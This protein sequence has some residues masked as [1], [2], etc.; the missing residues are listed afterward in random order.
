MN[1][2][3]KMMLT[4]NLSNIPD[5]IVLDPGQIS[6]KGSFKLDNSSPKAFIITTPTLKKRKS[7]ILVKK[8]I[9]IKEKE[10]VQKK[11]KF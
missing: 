9:D 2:L 5:E 7:D 11:L 3:C 8:C 10:P 4:I 6:P 1:E